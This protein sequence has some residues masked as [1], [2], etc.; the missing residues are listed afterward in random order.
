MNGI[1]IFVTLGPEIYLYSAAT[2]H[3]AKFSQA[4]HNSGLSA[5]RSFECQ[6]A[7]LSL[8]KDSYAWQHI[9]PQV[10]T[11][12]SL[13]AQFLRV[14]L[15]H[16]WRATE[17]R[18][19]SNLCHAPVLSPCHTLYFKLLLVGAVWWFRCG[20][21]AQRLVQSSKWR[22]LHGLCPRFLSC[23]EELSHKQRQCCG[24]LWA[25]MWVEYKLRWR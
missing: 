19:R 7:D 5:A 20:F 14:F 11:D 18:L 22:Q 1:A 6:M 9:C 12:N 17:S 2:P 4:E 16:H 23:Y 3:K 10:G 25:E 21:I 8:Q 13:L 24:E 15:F